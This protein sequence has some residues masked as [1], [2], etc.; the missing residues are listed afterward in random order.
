MT[1]LRSLESRRETKQIRSHQTMKLYR[2]ENHQYAVHERQRN[3]VAEYS[4]RS[5]RREVRQYIQ[6]NFGNRLP[7]HNNDQIDSGV[8]W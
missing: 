6:L 4:Y 1:Q 2:E 3:E 7:T 5:P 8:G